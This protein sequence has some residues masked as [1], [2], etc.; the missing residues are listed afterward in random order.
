MSKSAE[1]YFDSVVAPHLKDSEFKDDFLE[2]ATSMISS[3]YYQQFTNYAIALLAAHNMAMAG[4]DQGGSGRL[5]GQAGAVSRIKESELQVE[6]YLGTSSSKSGMISNLDQT[7]YGITLQDLRRVANLPIT[8]TGGVDNC[9]G[10][11]LL[12]SCAGGIV[13]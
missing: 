1:Q 7:S 9:N 12:R 6:Y 13:L 4:L 5:P 11:P 3:C 8:A 2:L 10:T